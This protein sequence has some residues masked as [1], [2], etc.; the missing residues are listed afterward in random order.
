MIICDVLGV[1]LEICAWG[2][3]ELLGPEMV[4]LSQ[5]LKTRALIPRSFPLCPPLYQQIEHFGFTIAQGTV[6]FSLIC[7]AAGI[8]F[9]KKNNQYSFILSLASCV[10]QEKFLEH[11]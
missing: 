8:L 3:G 9:F 5:L 10:S 7:Y 2:L 1:K 6:N 11:R 4:Y